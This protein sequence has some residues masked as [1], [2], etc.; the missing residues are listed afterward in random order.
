MTA[1]AARVLAA[2]ADQVPQAPFYGVDS[3]AVN[4]YVISSIAAFTLA[5]GALVRF[6]TTNPNTGSS[7]ANVGG[8]GTQPI[9]NQYGNALTGGE[10]SVPTWLQWTGS[11]WQLVGT[12][13]LPDKARTPTEISNS[14]VPTSYISLPGALR[15][16]GADATGTADSSTAII[17]AGKCNARVF[18]D[19]P[20][21]G[22]Y[23]IKSTVTLVNYPV[24]F[25][26]Q[27]KN[28]GD[29]SGNTGSL[30]IIDA[31]LG[32]AGNA[33]QASYID[34]LSFVDWGFKFATG[35]N[36]QFAF[37]VHAISAVDGQMRSSSFLRC[38]F[39]GIGAGDTNGALRVDTGT[40]SQEYS[41]FNVF[42]SCYFNGL[43][44]PARFTGNT[45]P[46]VFSNC[47]FLGYT[48]INAVNSLG[49]ITPGS[50][51]TNGTY[52]NVPL[53]GGAG[54]GAVAHIQ[55][56]GG[57]VS[58]VILVQGGTGYAAANAL[59]AS[60][61][62][63]GG[64]GSGFSVPAATVGTLNG[65]AIQVDYPGTEVKVSTSNYFEGFIVGVHLNGAANCIQGNN[66]YQGC[67][68]GYVWIQTSYSI[69]GH[70][71]TSEEG[72]A[73]VALGYSSLD[74]SQI[75]LTGRFG[76]LA[77]GG[78]MQSTRGFQEGDG[79]GTNLRTQLLGYGASPGVTMAA[80]GGGT[81]SGQTTTTWS[82]SYVGGHLY[83]DFNVRGTL[84]GSGTTALLLPVAG[85]SAVVSS[86]NPCSVTNNGSTAFGVA[87]V[88]A[89]GS[90]L[91]IG[92][93]AAGSGT[94][95]A[96]VVGAV[97]QIKIRIL[98]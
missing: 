56:V 4:A 70:Q 37:R 52:A 65:C 34:N 27:A 66:D 54:T 80:N 20:G 26:G 93:G 36:A 3:G 10:I 6:T 75:S 90:N 9:V 81:I 40:G 15:R 18:D 83:I 91:E 96:G 42:D 45:T 88:N 7:T 60:A 19:C 94:F 55:V 35:G 43:L 47:S 72:V 76:W 63:I 77:T 46:N 49:S 73:G 28:N 22:Q 2:F 24:S 39:I 78:A 8:T 68:Y 21:G 23:R 64:T 32:A 30:F 87:F 92:L 48:G 12:G 1:S 74:G 41:A 79:P 69:L 38:A 13:P 17:N 11:A 58:Q 53:T 44:A 82:V 29:V 51:Y 97:G 95:T 50:G 86:Q 61:A 33:F 57:V 25:Q 31:A 98:S 62:S 16:Y 71:S 59:S 84:T 85:L 89:F 67:L 5:T 14:I